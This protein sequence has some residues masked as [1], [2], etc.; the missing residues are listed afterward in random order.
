MLAIVVRYDDHVELCDQAGLSCTYDAIPQKKGP[1]GS[2][3]KVISEL[4]ETQKQSDLTTLMLQDGN[5]S[6]GSPPQ[7]PTHYTRA[8]GL[9]THKLIEGCTDFFFTQM[10]PT[11][12]ILYKDQIRHAVGDMGHSV[13]SYC[14]ITSFLAFMLIQPGIVLKTGYLMDQPAGSVT[15]PKMGSVLM[16]E[17][18]RV[19]KGY[20]YV[21]NP[22][23]NTVITSF[24]LF[25][26]SF[27]LNKHNT[28]WFHLREAT[29]LAQIL[30]MQ[31]ENT[32][33]F[34][35]VVE[36]SRKR[37]LFWLLFVTERAYALQKHRPLTLH[38]TISLPTV[39]QDPANYSLAGFIYL[40][41]LYRPFDDTFIGLWNKS[42]TDCSPLTLARLQQQL[43]EALPQFL[44]TTES[45][46]ADLRTS[47]QWL[48]TMVW[49]LSIANGFL[50]STSPDTSMTF[51]F[52]IEIAKDLVEVT[53]QFSKQSMEV[54]GI[55]LIE[56]VFDV[57][58]TLIDVMSCVPLESRKF[59][60]GPQEY[61]NSL[62]TLIS[63]LRGGESRFLPL[64]M[65]KIRDTLPAIGSQLPLHL[66]EKYN[67]SGHHGKR[68]DRPEQQVELKQENSGGSSSAGSSP[69]E[70][71]S[72][73]HYY[74]L[75]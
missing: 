57:A 17:A 27:G 52:P 67:G 32:Y 5:K 36:T 11:M 35:N 18:I 66:I 23:V 10:Y 28:A 74:P 34:D 13:E 1:K 26:C 75:A 30:G 21:E 69:F 55:G 47:Q 62:L 31:D 20:D 59:E 25:G 50:S 16:E 49:Q 64:V 48:R 7:S 71:P 65:A 53:R 38:A 72:F 58:C 24:F 12:P 15:N 61:L 73:M 29:A 6:Y 22:T 8:T 41:N 39:D 46:A 43:T 19:R 2:R 56:K 70:T 44:N 54:H 60:P 42:R 3:A 68:A 63:T 33:M 4:R 51:R 37:R 40:V 9:L 45:Q 14:L